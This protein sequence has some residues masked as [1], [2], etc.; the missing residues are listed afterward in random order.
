MSTEPSRSGFVERAESARRENEWQNN[1]ATH[2]VAGRATSA[3]DCGLLL[4][5]LGLDAA[6]ARSTDIAGH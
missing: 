2:T 3:E 1:R 6:A 5:M 4:E